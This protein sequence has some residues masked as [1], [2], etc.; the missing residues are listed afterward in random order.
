MS[1]HYWVASQQQ[2]VPTQLVGFLHGHKLTLALSLKNFSN[3]IKTT[4]LLFKKL[5]TSYNN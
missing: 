5:I 2:Y 4:I 3:D 1:S